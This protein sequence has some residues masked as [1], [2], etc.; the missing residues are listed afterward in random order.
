MEQPLV[1]VIIPC[2]R[3]AQYLGATLES[4][5]KQTYKAV[6]IIVVDDG[7][8]DNTREVV[9]PFLSAMPNLRYIHQENSG[10][11]TARNHGIRSSNGTYIMALDADD[12]IE[13][14]YIERCADYLSAHPEVKLVY[15]LADTFGKRTGAWDLPPYTF[16]A[17]L[18]TNMVHYCAMYRRKDF[19]R[20][21]GY[22][23]NMVKGF[24]DW[25]FWLYL[26]RPEDRVHCIQERLFHWRVLEVSRSLDADNNLQILLRQIYHNH[27]ELYRPYLQD[28]VYFH[29]MWAHHEWLYRRADEAR[30]SKAYRLGKFL[31]RPVYWL[32]NIFR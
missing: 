29:E 5:Q 20:T 30:H 10:V 23:P 21:E 3:K 25:D 16:E 28:I 26:L 12:A 4:M 2:Y 9:E 17:L 11:S 27:E 22:N 32:R 13:P 15:T 18:W 1:S 6:E 14:T 31:F 19:D 7:S 8:P 24:E